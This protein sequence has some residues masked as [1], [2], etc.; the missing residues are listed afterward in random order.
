MCLLL[1]L[2]GVKEDD[3]CIRLYS[4]EEEDKSG[5]TEMRKKK[6]DHVHVEKSKGS[7]DTKE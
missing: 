1:C 6:K 7:E 4:I 5:H 2:V 3:V